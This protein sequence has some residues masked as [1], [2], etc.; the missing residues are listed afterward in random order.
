MQWTANFQNLV[1]EQSL[2]LIDAILPEQPYANEYSL[3]YRPLNLS[4][5]KNLPL[6]EAALAAAEDQ[7]DQT[8]MLDRQERVEKNPS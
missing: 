3:K 2:D 4:E 8:L 7:R 6:P 1:Y 5:V